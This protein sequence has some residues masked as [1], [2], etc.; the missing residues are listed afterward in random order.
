[1]I[2]VAVS[3]STFI[4]KPG[5]QPVV[6][7]QL[8]ALCIFAA[9]FAQL[10]HGT[11]Q[12]KYAVTPASLIVSTE[13]EGSIEGSSTLPL[14]QNFSVGAP[15]K[16]EFYSPNY[17]NNYPNHTDC[18]KVLKAD[19]GHLLRLDFRD[20]FHLE[21]SEECRYDYLEVRDG[22]HGYS[23][24]I[25]TYCDNRFPPMLTSSDRYLW[26]R[27]HSDENIEYSGFK[28]VYQYIPRPTSAVYQPEINMCRIDVGGMEGWVN[29]SDIDLGR[30]QHSMSYGVPL[31][32]M[33]IIRVKEG[34]K[35][36]LSF[37]KFK[38]EKPND[39][40]SNFVDVFSTQ[41]DLPNRLK[42]FCGSIADSVTSTTNVLHVRFFGEAKAINST[43]E[44]LFTA[45]RDKGAGQGC[46]SDEF[47]CEDN[48]CISR[49][50]RCN[51]RINCRFRW[52]EDEC[53]NKHVS[54]LNSEH[55]IIILIIFTLILSGMCF[56]F[57]FN[58]SRKLI[59]D[60]RI[61]KEHIH[62][63]RENRLNEVGRGTCHTVS[64]SMLPDNSS[65]SFDAEK[66][67]SLMTRY[68]SEPPRCRDTTPDEE[69]PG[70]GCYVPSLVDGGASPVPVMRESP[71]TVAKNRYNG[72]YAGTHESFPTISKSPSIEMRDNECQ[73][74]SSL[75]QQN[76]VIPPPPPAPRYAA[77]HGRV[78]YEPRPYGFSMPRSATA[79]VSQSAA[80]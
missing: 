33:W 65:G 77:L 10:A 29:R 48:T 13:D 80:V 58:C 49:N 37:Q 34:W 38:L 3:M 19:A 40:D 39:C 55:I 21:P 56:A 69:D 61:M 73:T 4:E 25:G 30:V 66:I 53:I 44:A 46:D 78:P 68:S 45:F 11:Q 28:A 59:R 60:H 32:C 62:Q 31:D 74:R 12:P 42:N 5:F 54:I 8:F 63:S 15:E 35:I 24:L 41:T 64:M 2:Q 36:Q 22:A 14:C 43:F 76:D 52:D 6:P 47:D 70:Q 71:Q 9:L 7:R 57:I 75:F 51:G 20:D 16:M 17:P 26:L 67:R 18:I 50:M 1:M 72:L 27:F 79:R 23:T